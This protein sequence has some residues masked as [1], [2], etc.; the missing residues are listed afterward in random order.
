MSNPQ[1]PDIQ[2]PGAYSKPM[3]IGGRWRPALSGRTIVVE[4][5]GRR[6][7]LG[8]VPRG[9][10]ADVDLAVDA[11][12]A[13][14]PGWSRVAARDRGRLLLTIGEAL[15]ARQEE[16]ARLI[17]SETGNAL[18]TQARGE[19]RMVADA[20]RYFGGLAGELKGLTIPLGEGMLSYSRRES[21]GVV[22]AIVPWNA[23]AQLAALKIAPAVCA[24]NTIVLKAAED[25]PLAVLMIAEIC[26]DHLPP[27]V[28]NVV[29][30]YGKE[31][32]EPLAAHP[33]V[34]KVSFTGSTAV[35][36]AIMRAAAERV[37]PVSLELGGKSPSI[38]YPDADEDWVLDGIVASMR[39]T[40]QSQS[41]TAGSRMFLHADIYDSFLDRLVSRT[42]AL[43]IGDPLDEATDVG[44]IINERQFTKV[45]GYVADGLNRPEARLVTG[46]LPPKEGPLTKGYFA[47]PTIFAD[48]S[49]DWRLA[50]EEIFGPVLVAIPWRD[51]EEAIRMANDSHY[52]LAAYIWSRDIGRALRA[53]HAVEAGWV[54]VNQG[55][56]QA[57]GQSYGGIKESGIGREMSLEG[58]LDSFTETKSVNV[59]LAIPPLQPLR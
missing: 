44:A 54:Q 26:Q 45:C 48:T 22:G 19:A 12:A 46:G 32:G 3:L 47:V 8:E 57:L 2:A 35:G 36:K 31:C 43:K 37:A 13:A 4:N 58:M 41:C 53:A 33:L 50:R 51:E 18:R 9:E 16:L 59:N 40:R 6:E 42:S 11:A 24:G 55:G 30:G 15:E 1:T 20:F 17:A 29:T 49:N 7:P 34:R 38:V 52:G 21:L 5:P 10:Q 56:G 14:F 27:G 23:P 28:V 25:A 39:F